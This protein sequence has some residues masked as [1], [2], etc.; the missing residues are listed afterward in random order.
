VT[1]SSRATPLSI[2]N[3]EVKPASTDDSRK[4]KVGGRGDNKAK[5]KRDGAGTGVKPASTDDSRKAKVGDCGNF[6]SKFKNKIA[7]NFL[8]NQTIM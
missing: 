1:F 5:A 2:P 3:R 6:I 8:Y 4:A 7:A